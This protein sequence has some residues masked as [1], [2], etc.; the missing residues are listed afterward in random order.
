MKSITGRGDDT[1]ASTDDKWA[2]VQRREGITYS[3]NDSTII[4]WE[5]YKKC[6]GRVEVQTY[7]PLRHQEKDQVREPFTLCYEH[8]LYPFVSFQTEI[9]DKGWYSPRGVGD[10]VAAHE[11]SLCRLWNGKHDCMDYL[12]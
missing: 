5:I 12:Q 1:G 11:D 8:N 4:L 10:I 7:S 2:T 3:K 9:K 6:D